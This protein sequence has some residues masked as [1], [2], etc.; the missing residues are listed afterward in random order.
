MRMAAPWGVLALSAAMASSAVALGFSGDAD[1][2]VVFSSIAVLGMVFGVAGALIV[3]RSSGNLIGWIFCS[4]A[5]VFEASILGEAYVGY[6]G[7]A[8]RP[9]SEWI[10]WANQSLGNALA[11]T[12]IILCFLLF[13]TGR[14]PSPRWRVVVWTVAAVALVHV[15]SVAL[16]PGVL[17]DSG[18][19]NPAGVEGAPYLG[20]VADASILVLVAPLMLLSA[21]SLFARLRRSSGAERQQL[22]WFAYAAALLATYLVAGNSAEILIGGSVEGEVADLVFF[23]IFAAVLS[24]IPVAMGV[25]ILRYRL[26]DIDLIINR[27]LVYGLL[28]ASLALVYFGGVVGLQRL[29]SPLVGEGNQLAV[30]ASTLAIAALFGPFRRR[31]QNFIDRRFY[32]KKYD[33][34]KT[35]DDFSA[36]LRSETNLETLGGDLVSVAHET[37]RPTHASLWLRPSD[38]E[39][40][41]GS[42]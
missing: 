26:Y 15:V 36:R 30:V 1:E 18:L 16:A 2:I 40:K 34:K 28:T 7:D 38:G 13:P 14:L 39:E 19:E 22:K 42:L 27:T 20:T 25:A 24:G 23:L 33:A 9:G 31:I 32:R 10:A 3:S 5:L 41:G 21:L 37:V 12:L 11:P 35:L 29:F 6:D 17:E 4:L 8:S